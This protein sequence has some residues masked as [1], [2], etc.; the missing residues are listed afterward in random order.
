MNGSI[1]NQIKSVLLRGVCLH[2]ALNVQRGGIA[3]NRLQRAVKRIAVNARLKAEEDLG[4][5]PAIGDVIRFILRETLAEVA[6]RI[7]GTR[8]T[9]NGKVPAIER[10]EVI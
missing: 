6:Q 2:K 9:L 3:K 5:R 8:M 10:V 4:V 1:G 7:F